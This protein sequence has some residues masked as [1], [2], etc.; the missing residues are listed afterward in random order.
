MKHL[1]I[2]CICLMTSLFGF[3]QEQRDSMANNYVSEHVK[4]MGIAMEGPLEEF[5]DKLIA[6]GLKFYMVNEKNVTILTG[7]FAGHQAFIILQPNRNNE[8]FRVQVIFADGKN[9]FTSWKELSNLYYDLK[10]LLISKYGQP[11]ECTEKFIGKK[12]TNDRDRILAVAQEKCDYNCYFS[13]QGEA[14]YEGGSVIISIDEFPI[15]SISLNIAEQVIRL[16]YIDLQQEIKQ[17]H[18]NI[19]DI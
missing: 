7:L 6:K 18:Q 5:K 3:S 4:F 9:C 15:G 12:P 1:L 11:K 16:T 10:K 13:L 2:L 17:D 14:T 19:D 8:I